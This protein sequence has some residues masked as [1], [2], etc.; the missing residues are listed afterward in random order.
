MS[1]RL[2]LLTRG[3]SGRSRAHEGRGERERRRGA[4][5]IGALLRLLRCRNPHHV[6]YMS[7][8]VTI[9]E[10]HRDNDRQY[11]SLARHLAASEQHTTASE[12]H[13]PHRTT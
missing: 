8:G 4:G 12:P 7:V 1:C 5:L 11:Y 13:P 3:S 6:S 9:I 10:K 2:C